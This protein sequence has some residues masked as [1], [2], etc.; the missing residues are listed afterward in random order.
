MNAGMIKNICLCLFVLA[1]TCADYEMLDEL[2][3]DP[4]AVTLAIS[5]VTDSSVTL[6]W[7]KYRDDDFSRYEVYFGT[8]DI[9]DRSDEFSD[10]LLFS[11]DTVKIVQPLDDLQRYYFRVLVVN[12]TGRFSASNTVDTVTPEN[13]RGKLKLAAPVRTD[14]GDLRLSWTAA[15]EPIDRYEIFA[16]TLHTVDTTDTSVATV[17]SDTAETV[18]GLVSDRTW[19]L[20]VYALRDTAIV[21]TSNSVAITRIEN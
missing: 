21:A 16:D 11:S 12:E 14:A 8:N 15:L 5:N 7:T 6:R 17:Y 3:E 4:D 10:S 1:L 20:R 18:T 13:M 2:E 19:W 9:V